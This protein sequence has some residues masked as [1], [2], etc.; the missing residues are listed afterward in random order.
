MAGWCNDNHKK[1]GKDRTPFPKHLITDAAFHDGEPRHFQ[2][3]VIKEFKTNIEFSSYLHKV[4]SSGTMDLYDD[5]PMWAW[6]TAVYHDPLMPKAKKLA[7][8]HRYIP[9]EL[10]KNS[11]RLDQ[12]AARHHARSYWKIFRQNPTAARVLAADIL[13]DWGDSMEQTMNRDRISSSNSLLTAIAH[14]YW[15][16]KEKKRK[17]GLTTRKSKASLNRFILV[18]PNTVSLV[19]DIDKLQPNRIFAI[20]G[21]EFMNSRYMLTP[22]KRAPKKKK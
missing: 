6:I 2:I 5:C 8:D 4:F 17:A 14:L 22:K 19:Y 11:S 21:D 9:A 10:L 3:D 20:A 12:V 15:D 16:K 7:M 18:I 1:Y 13:G